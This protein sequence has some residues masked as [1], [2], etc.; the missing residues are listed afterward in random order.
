MIECIGGEQE[1]NANQP[2]TNFVNTFTLIFIW[3]RIH[4]NTNIYMC[5]HLY[6][7][8]N[9][10]S[11]ICIGTYTY[12]G[13]VAYVWFVRCSRVCASVRGRSVS[14][15]IGFWLPFTAP[16]FVAIPLGLSSATS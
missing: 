10:Y 14:R 15:F 9:I 6:I 13:S 1:Q 16:P 12:V 4:L 3:A 8:A 5:I 11:Y 7:L 2:W